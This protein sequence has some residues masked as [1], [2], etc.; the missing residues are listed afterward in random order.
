MLFEQ[1]CVSI[2]CPCRFR[3]SADAWEGNFSD[4]LISW[5]C[6]IVKNWSTYNSVAEHLYGINK[7]VFG[8]EATAF[9]NGY[10]RKKLSA[11]VG[12]LE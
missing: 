4:V 3:Y 9:T 11:D 5:A 7:I 6:K 1:N 10:L 2:F 8:L 12:E